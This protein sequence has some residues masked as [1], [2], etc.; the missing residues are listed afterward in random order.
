MNETQEY[1]FN[2]ITKNI[3]HG[4]NILL[5]GPGGVGKSYLIRKI[6][7]YLE[8]EKYY[9]YITA[10]TGIAAVNL[11][12]SHKESSEKCNLSEVENIP[13]PLLRVTTIH[14][15]AGV[16]SG[17]NSSDK[18]LEYL[19]KDKSCVNRWVKCQ[20][21]IIDEISM[22]GGAFFQKLN[23]IAQKLRKCTF[24]FGGMQL[25]VSG[26]FLQLPPVK[27][28]WVF[29]CDAWKDMNFIP[30][31]LETPMRYS[32]RTFFDFLLRIRTGEPTRADLRLLK[33]RVK[34]NKKMNEYITDLEKKNP[35]MQIIKP[36][37]FYSTRAKV[38]LF[39]ETELNK[40]PGKLHTFKAVDSFVI[41]KGKPVKETYSKLFD[42]DTPSI[43][44]FKIGA[45]VMLRVNLDVSQG[46]ANGSRG[47]IYNI[48]NGAIYVEFLNGKK[49]AIVPHPRE[50]AD[51]YCI[52]KRTQIPLVLAFS[53]T[54]HK[55][56]GSTL[57]YVAVNLGASIFSEG[58]VYVA[59]SRCSSLSGLFVTEFWSNSILTN[60][61]AKDYAKKIKREWQDTMYKNFHYKLFLLKKYV[62][63]KDILQII[64][65]LYSVVLYHQ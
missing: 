7:N 28:S 27:D 35:K 37:M 62:K 1:I 51:K 32:D 57:D 6:S 33:A 36:T 42:E 19:K 41:I 17:E 53:Y 44:H 2:S 45:Q 3:L 5:H 56:Q 21:L 59:L 11:S 63:I 65:N 10:T 39:N 49:Y 30:Y 38:N 55:S 18:L 43:L 25:I 31:I 60:K 47:V 24:P 48:E 8:A 16:G 52:A 9:I 34:A 64:W 61:T 46:L 54:I 12:E 58:Q 15:F 4:K 23:F 26:D 29:T 13:D 50:I 14:K 40:L 22:L 20:I